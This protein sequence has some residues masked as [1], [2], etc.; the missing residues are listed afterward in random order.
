MDAAK[1]F[2]NDPVL[3]VNKSLCSAPQTNPTVAVVEEHKIIYY[4]PASGASGNVSV[5]SGG[6]SG[7]EPAFGGYVGQGLLSAS[8]AGSIFASPNA[9]QIEHCMS[10]C[11]DGTNGILVIIMNYTVSTDDA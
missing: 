5:I 6:G 4:R 9:G 11:V 8:V 7:H 10:Q 2:L 3:L 1:H